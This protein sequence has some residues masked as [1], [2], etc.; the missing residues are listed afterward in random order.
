MELVAGKAFPGWGWWVAQGATTLWGNWD[1]KSSRNHHM[2]STVS[3]WLYHNLGGIRPQQAKPGFHRFWLEPRP[4]A[5]AA[6][7]CCSHETPYGRIESSWTNKDGIFTW[8]ITVPPGTAA[9][10]ILPYPGACR[11]NETPVQ[12]EEG[13]VLLQQGRYLLVLQEEQAGGEKDDIP[14]AVNPRLTLEQRKREKGASMMEKRLLKKYENNPVVTP[15]MMPKPVLY[16]FN[17]GA[18]KYNGEY[19]LI[20]DCTTLDDIHRFWIARSKDGYSFTPDPS[21]STGLHPIQSIRSFV[22]MTPALQK[23]GRNISSFM[24]VICLRTKLGWAL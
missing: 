8:E 21:R 17:P 1:G 16:T 13:A 22:P 18:I 4:C 19:I 6:S 11:I 15:A 9:D 23:S 14:K 12:T 2:F 5:G 24:Q 7:V 3:S 10:V 20:M